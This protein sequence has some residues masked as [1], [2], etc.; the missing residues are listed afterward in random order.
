MRKE[1]K[2]GL[3]IGGLLLLGGATYAA[4]KY[5]K[6]KGKFDLEGFL[7]SLPKKKVSVFA[8]DPIKQKEDEFLKDQE[9]YGYSGDPTDWMPEK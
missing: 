3:M 1:V 8:D 7:K 2:V 4:V 6:E 9:I 5:K